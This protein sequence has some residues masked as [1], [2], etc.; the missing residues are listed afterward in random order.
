LF[1]GGQLPTASALVGR[2]AS[3]ARRSI[4]HYCVG[5]IFG[6]SLGPLTSGAVAAAFCLRWVFLVTAAAVLLANLLWVYFRVPEY[7]DRQN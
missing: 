4:R 3:G 1:I 6:N 2:A 5:H 7:S